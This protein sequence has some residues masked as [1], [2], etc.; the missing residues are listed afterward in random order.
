MTGRAEALRRASRE[1]A[2]SCGAT[3]AL[4]RSVSEVPKMSAKHLKATRSDAIHR[5]GE[6]C[7]WAR[8]ARSF[9]L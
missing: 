7:V 6:T 3:V 2:S 5:R 1:E 8:T 4:R 9:S